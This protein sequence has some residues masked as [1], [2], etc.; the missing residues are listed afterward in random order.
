MF[1]YEWFP[2][3]EVDDLSDTERVFLKRLRERAG[4]W[5]H[6]PES[7]QLVEP[8]NELLYWRAV[9]DIVDEAKNRHLFTIG[10]CFDGASIWGGELDQYYRPVPWDRSRVEFIQV[11]GAPED[12]AEI[13]AD[14][15][16]RVLAG[17]MAPRT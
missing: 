6:P 11:G 16:E 1:S 10:L 4:S 5:N 7:T 12:L 3:D 15:F 9:F 2:E 8:D 17:L 14:W 13:A